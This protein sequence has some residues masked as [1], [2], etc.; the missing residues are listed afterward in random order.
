MYVLEHFHNLGSRIWY[1]LVSSQYT[2]AVG[3][4]HGRLDAISWYY[5]LKGS[6]IDGEFVPISKWNLFSL[7]GV[8]MLFVDTPKESTCP[9][10]DIRY[11]PKED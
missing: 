7:S 11:L 2:P 6:L 8:L 1:D 5:N 9:H 10:R 3:C 4:S